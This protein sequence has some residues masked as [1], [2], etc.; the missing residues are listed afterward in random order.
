MSDSIDVTLG[1]IYAKMHKH[2]GPQNRWLAETPL[3][4]MIGA[5]LGQNSS[6][7]NVD[8]ALASLREAKLLEVEKILT[9]PLDRLA[10]YLRPAGYYNIKAQR[11][12]NL[13]Q[14]INDLTGGNV[15]K[16]LAFDQ[17]E[18]R[19]ILVSVKGIGP[20]TAD[21]ILLYAAGQP[22]FIVDSYTFRIFYRHQLLADSVTYYELQELFMDNLSHDVQTFHEYHALLVLVGK[23]F[24][25]K[26]HPLCSKCPLQEY[27][28]WVPS[29]EE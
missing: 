3:E 7:V 9:T 2:F 22:V 12:R 1:N 29:V 20:E 16:F 13:C 27:A 23:K 10:D 15:E 19:E 5:I 4:M 11:L 21:S 6:W 26:S 17:V 18:L 14:C 8:K 24:C 25:R 28:G